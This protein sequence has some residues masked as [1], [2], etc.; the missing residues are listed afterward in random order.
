MSKKAGPEATN[1][2]ERQLTSLIPLRLAVTNPAGV[3]PDEWNALPHMD[4]G[5][6]WEWDPQKSGE[7]LAGKVEAINTMRLGG[8]A[9]VIAASPDYL[10]PFGTPPTKVLIKRGGQVLAARMTELEV[11]PGDHVGIKY[12]GEGAPKAGQSAPRLWHVVKFL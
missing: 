8:L 2:A 9:Y 7:M 10:D 1:V 6:E 5:V 12:L 4:A 3:I 11:R